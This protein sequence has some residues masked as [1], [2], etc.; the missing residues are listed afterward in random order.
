MERVLDYLDF[1]VDARQ[2]GKVRHKIK[3]WEVGRTC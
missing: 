2:S 3:D 1:A